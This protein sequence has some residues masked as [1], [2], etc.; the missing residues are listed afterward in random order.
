[1][2]IT[3]INTKIMGRDYTDWIRL[4][5]YRNQCPFVVVVMEKVYETSY[6]VT[7]EEFINQLSYYQHLKKTVP[8]N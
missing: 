3:T 8:H 6:F 1:M 5:H 4:A 7:F 2:N